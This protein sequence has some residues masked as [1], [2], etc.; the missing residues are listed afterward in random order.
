M[1]QPFLNADPRPLITFLA[2]LFQLGLV[3]T[4]S[5]LTE[6]KL[7]RWLLIPAAIQIAILGIPIYI[8]P[9][10]LRWRDTPAIEAFV[11]MMRDPVAEVAPNADVRCAIFRPSLFKKSLIEVVIYTTAGL[12]R[13]KNKYMTVHQGVAGMAYRT[14]QTSYVPI[15]AGNWK[16]RLMNDLG[17]TEREVMRFKPDRGSY[18]SIPVLKRVSEQEVEVLAVVSL[19]SSSDGT[20]TPAMIAEIERVAT[21][22]AGIL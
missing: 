15:Q 12:E 6:E 1:I 16:T 5:I 18:L 10:L 19:D 7:Y 2:G 22:I 4:V 3:Y 14:K 9:K 20:F 21:Y 11:R 8:L 17:F 13:R